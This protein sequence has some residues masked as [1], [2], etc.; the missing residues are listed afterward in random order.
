MPGSLPQRIPLFP[1]PSTVL[2][3]GVPLPL[4]IFEPRYREM[5]ADAL[6]GEGIIGMVLLKPGFEADY[7]GRPPIYE[8]GCAG[9]ISKY[10]QLSDG[11]YNLILVGKTRFHVESESAE[12]S[13]R[14]GE[15]TALQENSG[16]DATTAALREQV[17]EHLKVLARLSG[18][19]EELAAKPPPGGISDYEFVNFLSHI[20]TVSPLE[21]QALLEESGVTAR[22]RKLNDIL[23][24]WRLGRE[25]GMGPAQ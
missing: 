3:P 9:Y 22:Y 1:L 10:E 14:T 21:K 4:H 24:F 16:S 19:P 2:F 23:E 15:V 20:I 17:Q 8:I 25:R 13:Y 11:R 5:M 6:A 18:T 12:R 7:E